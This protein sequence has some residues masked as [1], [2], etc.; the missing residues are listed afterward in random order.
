M[1][2]LNSHD[3]RA[4]CIT[5]FTAYSKRDE[6]VE[7]LMKEDTDIRFF[8]LTPEMAELKSYIIE[9]MFDKFAISHVV[10]DEAHCI[11]DKS[12]RSSFDALRELRTKNQE[13]PFIA[14]TTASR[15]TIA[16]IIQKLGM[17]EEAT[18]VEASS[19]R[20]NIFYDVIKLPAFGKIDFLRYMKRI[21]PEFEP[22][23]PEKMPSGIIYCS[24]NETVEKICKTL[25]ELS[26]PA[27]TYYGT[28][29]NRS[30]NYEAWS[31]QDVAIMVAT[32][33]SFGLGIVNQCVKFVIHADL[34][35]NLRSYY[36]VST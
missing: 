25:A 4:E 17:A 29:Q 7:E 1:S 14:L 15:E 20:S 34:P 31:H 5:S 19:V 16:K 8:Y 33:E 10:V 26:I 11:I 35:K 18:I 2:F 27:T 21:I 9:R 32:T 30:S 28:L 6:I 24:T 36:Q 12:F 3:I 13:V 23:Q 22:L